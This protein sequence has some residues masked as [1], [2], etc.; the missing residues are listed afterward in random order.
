MLTIA[1]ALSALIALTF[2]CSAAAQP[3]VR[4]GDDIVPAPEADRKL[5]RS[6]PEFKDKGEVVD[7]RRI[8]ILTAKT[9]Y[10]VGEEVR[11]IHVLKATKPGLTVYSM[12][13]KT[14][15]EDYVDDKLAVQQGPDRTGYHGRVMR[16]PAVD[17]NYEITSYRFAKPGTH[18]IFWRG[19]GYEV[20]HR[21]SITSDIG[22]ISN[23]IELVVKPRPVAS[24]Q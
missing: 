15:D 20:C 18:T 10:E 21:L 3:F 24:N 19:G 23:K 9:E 11:V 22:L 12:G 7:G 16:S 14:I 8:T 4:K 13:P 2:A 1:P 5:A 6:Y 17:L